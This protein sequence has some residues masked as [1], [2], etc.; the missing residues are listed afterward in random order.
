MAGIRLGYTVSNP[1]ITA[2]FNKVRTMVEA[3]GIS[4][5]LAERMLQRPGDIERSIE[6]L[7][8]GRKYFAAEVNKMGFFALETAGNFIHVDF[9]DKRKDVEALLAGKV[10]FR[11]FPTPPLEQFLR[12]TT[13]TIERFEPVVAL[14][15][16]AA[17]ASR[18]G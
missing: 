6:R 16:T 13:T 1:E 11:V 15:K 18:P 8:E 7:I 12:F 17:P 3:D 4:M 9:G 2:N 5:A 14:L 10:L